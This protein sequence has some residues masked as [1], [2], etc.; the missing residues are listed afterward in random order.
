MR[1]EITTGLPTRI[2]LANPSSTTTWTARS[3]LGSSP[4]A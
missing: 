1:F 2:G 3:T 4:S